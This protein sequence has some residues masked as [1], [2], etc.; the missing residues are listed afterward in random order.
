MIKNV[1]SA[2]KII[3]LLVGI[4]LIAAPFVSGSAA[5]SS[6]IATTAAVIVGIVLIGTAIFSFCPLYR[7]IGIRTRRP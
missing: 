5:F 2:D 7:L 3:R 6:N 4:V 1:G